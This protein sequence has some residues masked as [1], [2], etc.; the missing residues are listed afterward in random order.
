M[1]V[2][3]GTKNPAK[4]EG[5]R[6]AFSKYFNDLTIE[7]ISVDSNVNEQPVNEET[8][9][10]A[11]NRVTNLKK[12]CK[13]NGI[14]SDLFIAI[15]SGIV[16]QFGKWFIVN[17]AVIEDSESFISSGLSQGFPVPD[18]YVETIVTKGLADFMDNLFKFEDLRSQAGGISLLTNG[19]VLRSDLT[20]QAFIM[21][22]T[23]YINKDIWN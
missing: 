11:K 7:G 3:I 14:K 1:K 10:G 4:I 8:Y 13:E 23:R 22:L 15:E 21:A 2:F 20:E 18:Q 19:V 5:A 17:V 9:I 6:K 12:Y 16:M